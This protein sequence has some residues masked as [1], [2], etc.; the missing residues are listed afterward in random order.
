MGTRRS[1]P[2]LSRRT[3]VAGLGAGGLAVALAARGTAAQEG[4]A[5][6]AGHPLVGSWA[7]QTLGGVVPQLHGADGSIVAYFPPS[8]VDATLGLTFQGPALGRWEADGE[9]GGRFTFLQALSDGD[10][11]YVGTFQLSAGIEASEDGGTW[12]GIDQPRIIVRDAANTVV[13]DEVLPLDPTPTATRIGA[14][15]DSVVLPVGPATGATPST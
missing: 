2:T 5:E 9:R 7:V 10:G 11:A 13:A 4:T 12:A 15:A 3:A 1:D 14:T 6:M 8:Y